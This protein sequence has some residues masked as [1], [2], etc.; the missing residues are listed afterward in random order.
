M[1]RPSGQIPDDFKITPIN[2]RQRRAVHEDGIIVEPTLGEALRRLQEPLAFLD[3]ETLARAIP[4]WDG[5]K[6]WEQVPAQLSCHV[7]GED[8]KVRHFEWLANGPG[9][10]RPGIATELIEACSG[11]RYILAYNAA[12]EEGCIV[13]LAKVLP[14]LREALLSVAERLVDLLPIVR[15][16][17]YHPDFDGSF[18]L[19]AVVPALKLGSYKELEIASGGEATLGLVRLLLTTD[20]L[21]PEEREALRAKLL[22]YC[23][24]DTRYLVDLLDSL[25]QM[26]AS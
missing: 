11:A 1:W 24:M 14:D 5:C 4:V 18:S 20:V 7:R 23:K 10:P 25:R 12:F 16:N 17:V 21:A 3:F 26:A 9:D 15:D 19:K 22:K 6:P 8:A 13:G 2:A